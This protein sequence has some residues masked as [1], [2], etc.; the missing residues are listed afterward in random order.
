MLSRVIFAL[1][2]FRN[3][4]TL[5]KYFC[6]FICSGRN[7]EYG[8][9]MACLSRSEVDRNPFQK[10][11]ELSRGRKNLREQVTQV[12][13]KYLICHGIGQNYTLDEV[14]KL[15]ESNIKK[16]CNL[17][18]GTVLELNM[19]QE[20]NHQLCQDFSFWSDVT[21]SF[22]N[23]CISDENGDYPVVRKCITHKM[24][25]NKEM[26]N[27]YCGF[28]WNCLI[29]RIEACP[30]SKT[31]SE[32]DKTDDFYCSKSMSCIRKSDIC[33]GIVHCY[34]GE[35]EDLETCAHIY[36]QTATIKC[37]EINRGRIETLFVE[38]PYINKSIIHTVEY[39]K[40]HYFVS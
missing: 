30:N 15:D 6:F 21:K 18:D 36:P 22:N 7:F 23:S 11:K 24:P 17:K 37:L 26:I 3:S 16:Q 33:D 4:E 10:K 34:H 27:K 8:L 12:T 19:A 40:Q 20:G 13:E 5:F 39:Y 2:C 1:I 35:D 38:I 9:G 25:A 32:C 29:R 31:K 14:C 28:S